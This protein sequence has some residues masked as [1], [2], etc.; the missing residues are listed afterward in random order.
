MIAAL[1]T[2]LILGGGVESAVLDYVKYIRGTVA[3][4]VAD[5]DRKAEARSILDDA[6][7]L[8]KDHA[9]TNETAFESLL[10]ETG[11]IDADVTTIESLWEDHHQAVKNYNEQMID[12]RFRLRDTLTR[13]EWE[14]LFAGP[15][16]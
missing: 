7:K 4:V 9:R 1:I 16:E 12:L 13:D 14:A 3:D 15:A 8:T 6:K 11:S 2:I 10:A 5:D